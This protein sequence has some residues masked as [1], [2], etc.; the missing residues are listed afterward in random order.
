MN[1][2][3]NVLKQK[4]NLILMNGQLA[5]KWMPRQG[6]IAAEIRKFFGMTPKQYRKSLV[7]LTKVVEQQMC[8]NQWDDINFSHVP[9]VAHAR[10][11]KAFGRNT[12]MYAKYVTSLVK[13]DNPLV[14]VNAGAVFPYDVLKG[15]INLYGYKNFNKTELDLIVKQWE[16]L[17]NFIGDANVLPLVDVSGSMTCKAG[18]AFSKSEVTC[19]DV[20]VS[21]GLYCADKNTGKFKDMFLT[22]SEKSEL[23]LL[24]GN[25]LEKSQQMVQSTWGMNTNLVAAMEKILKVAVDGSVPSDEMPKILLIMSDMQFDRCARFDDSAIGMI[26]RKY[27]TAGYQMPQIVFWNLNAGD[28]VPVKAN[29]TGVALVSGF[30]PAIVKSVLS[31]DVEEFT[32]RGIMMKTIMNPRYDV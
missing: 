5:S 8:A 16:A 20:A 17:P 26:R 19:L 6:P 15:V 1:T 10:Y 9:S 21:L 11:K 22:F 2:A 23:L 4:L 28:N 14:K 12:P 13:G 30:S 7:A 32:P 29:E 18:G 3:K 27:E 24:R 31:A 25:V